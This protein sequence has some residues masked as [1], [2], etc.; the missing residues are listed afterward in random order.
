MENQAVCGLQ[1]AKLY[2]PAFSPDLPDWCTPLDDP[3]WVRPS[4]ASLMRDEDPVLGF[5]AAGRM[6]A[7]PWWVMK[8]HHVANLTLE[9]QSFLVTLCEACVAGGVFDPTLG[10]RRGSFQV[11]G[12]YNGSPLMTDDLT[13]SLWVLPYGRC[14][15][16]PSEGVTLPM[17]PI[18]HAPWREWAMMYPQAL[19][20]HGEGEPRDGHG[21]E[22]WGPG[23]RL[24]GRQ[25]LRGIGV[26]EL[27]VSVELGETRRAYLLA[28]VHEQGGIVEDTVDGCPLVVVTL[29]GTWLCVVFVSAVDGTP[30]HLGW[31]P[32]EN[33]PT[34]LI[35]RTSGWRFD[36][37]GRCL[38]DEH[39]GVGLPYVRSS[40]K[41][42]FSWATANPDADSWPSGRAQATVS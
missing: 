12:W 11:N 6:W 26:N 23:H 27:V 32:I 39:G 14:V 7:I 30:V 28:D 5:E 19:V 18:V 8:N 20:V 35:D 1:G 13:G 38:T 25:Q 9:G 42:W 15:A 31:D 41:K 36:L 3:R 34:H 40:L 24:G 29:P 4:E 33:P 17:R 21:A 22:F 37:W 16:G 10:G 2:G